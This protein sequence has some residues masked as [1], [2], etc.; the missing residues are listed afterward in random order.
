MERV[1][2]LDGLVEAWTR[3][4]AT[5]QVIELLSAVGIPCGPVS[6]VDD[7]LTDE[8]L[9]HRGMILSATDPITDRPL[10][11]PGNV[12]G[13]WLQTKS[14]SVPKRDSGRNSLID[15]R[16]AADVAPSR[17][18]EP[19]LA[20][21][22]VVELG[23]W[24]TA[25][26]ASRLLA[27]L[28][29][30]VLKIEPPP[31]GDPARMSAPFANG[32][33]YLFN[34]NNAQKECVDIDLRTEEGKKDF[35]QIISRSDVFIENL[36][37][38]SLSKLGYSFEV[39]TGLNSEIVYCAI[40]GFGAH[41][42]YAGRPAMDTV[43]QSMCGVMHLTKSDGVPFKFGV[44]ISDL[45]G[46]YFGLLG[47]VAA[48]EVRD[49]GLGRA[50][51]LDL[52]MQDMTAWATQHNWNDPAPECSVEKCTDGYVVVER[53]GTPASIEGDHSLTRRERAAA[54]QAR[55]IRATPILTVGE[56]AA[57]DQ[58]RKRG[59]LRTS[60]DVLAGALPLLAVPLGLQKTPPVVN[61]PPR[62]LPSVSTV[63]ERWQVRNQALQRSS[64]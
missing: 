50:Q 47:V 35:E 59:L 16:L 1:E 24:T 37:P 19:P 20:G 4:R 13:P 51:F 14:A 6:T 5:N 60:G 25:P 34:M 17:S 33:S 31:A 54:L 7:L 2:A 44:S 49:K 61:A 56:V 58:T 40:S 63:L 30:E 9:R 53:Q 11:I 23:Q 10:K 46:G 15:L 26:L 8:N 55:G 29:A 62:K 57:S 3:N 52:S 22:R 12:F 42:A 64:V 43:L 28:G 18:P 36:K 27:S 39:L 48:L 41:S 38:G 45:M 32:E 21:V